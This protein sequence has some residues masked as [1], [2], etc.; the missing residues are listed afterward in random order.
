VT[1]LTIKIIRLYQAGISP[2]LPSVCRFEPTCSEYS[3]DAIKNFGLVKGFF[4][5]IKRLLRCNP[6]GGQGY[7]PI[8]K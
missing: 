1:L 3:I 8:S 5:A 2:Y 7:D 6:L 4:L